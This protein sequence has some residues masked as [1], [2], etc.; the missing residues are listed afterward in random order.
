MCLDSCAASYKF[1]GP[2]DKVEVGY[3]LSLIHKVQCEPMFVNVSHCLSS[4][5]RAKKAKCNVNL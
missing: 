1:P 3:C 4:S 5:Y 2:E